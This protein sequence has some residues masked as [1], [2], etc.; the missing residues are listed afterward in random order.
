MKKAKKRQPQTG[1]AGPFEISIKKKLK[2]LKVTPNSMN[3]SIT[4]H[5]TI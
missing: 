4:L 3:I 5:N 2:Q 1:S